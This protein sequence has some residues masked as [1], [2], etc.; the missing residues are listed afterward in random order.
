MECYFRNNY[1]PFCRVHQTLL[2]A[3]LLR[4]LRIKL[5][6]I[7]HPNPIFLDTVDGQKTKKSEKIKGQKTKKSEKAKGLDYTAT[8]SGEFSAGQAK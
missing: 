1:K 3:L 2:N 4:I 6:H 8:L 5:T 7:L